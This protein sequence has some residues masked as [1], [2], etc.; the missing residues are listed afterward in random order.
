MLIANKSSF[1]SSFGFGFY[2]I[3]IFFDLIFPL[4]HVSFC[5]LASGF[6]LQHHDLIIKSVWLD[7]IRINGD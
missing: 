7:K 3:I 2:F 4:S 6:E 5:H 1:N